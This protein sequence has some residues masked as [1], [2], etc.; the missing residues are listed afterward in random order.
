MV[1]KSC[2]ISS[3]FFLFFCTESEVISKFISHA[4][5]QALVFYADIV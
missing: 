5:V 2:D 1:A 3:N 4:H